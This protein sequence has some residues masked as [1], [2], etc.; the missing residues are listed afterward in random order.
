MRARLGG[1][2]L[3]EGECRYGEGILYAVQNLRRRVGRG[4]C[5]KVGVRNARQTDSRSFLGRLSMGESRERKRVTFGS[6]DGI[7]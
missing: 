5:F 7:L 4:R 2:I 1:R 6:R 3:V